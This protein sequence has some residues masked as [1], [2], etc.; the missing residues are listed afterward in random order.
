[1]ARKFSRHEQFLRIFSLLEILS[2]SHSPLTDDVLINTLRDRLGLSRLSARTL[3]RDC[4]F[5]TSCG[6]PIDHVQ[7]PRERKYGWKLQSDGPLAK[8]ILV[9]PLTL[10]ELVAFR[11][12]RSHLK[13]YEGTPLWSGIEM[14]RSRFDRAIPKAI[15]A[16]LDEHFAA[17]YVAVDGSK[18]YASRPRL[19]STLAA[20]VV[21]CR[22][23]EMDHR[24]GD[25]KSKARC[26]FQPHRLVI[27]AERLLLFGYVA[28]GDG[29]AGRASML[30]VEGIRNVRVKDGRF[31]PN[32][33]ADADL[34]RLRGK[35]DD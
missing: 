5:L 17:F 27:E 20:A 29:L 33:H 35:S 31:Q 4:E 12:A 19:I 1:M 8:K 21:A 7:I 9:E 22:L 15:Q 24:G 10:L 13:P 30:P 2:A 28:D 16:Q 6:Y 23:I 26:L 25:G 11:V 3:R 34:D 18:K 14:L 32:G